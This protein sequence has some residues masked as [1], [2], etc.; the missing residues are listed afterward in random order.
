MGLFGK[1]KNIFY[2]EEIVEVP[3]E[4]VKKEE[5][6]KV[7]EFK[8]PVRRVVEEEPKKETTRP[9]PEEKPVPPVYTERELFKSE[10][11][12]KFP[13]IDEEEEE[14]V[15]R[16]RPNILDIE[17]TPKRRTEEPRMETKYNEKKEEPKEIRVF[18]PSPVISP[19]YGVLDKNYKKEEIIERQNSI[20][21][22][23][24]E[25]NYDSVR[26]KAYG[27]LED[28]F[29]NTLSRITS[30]DKIKEQIVENKTENIGDNKPSDNKSIQDLLSEIEVNRNIS[31]GD[32]EEKIKDKIENDE[33][34]PGIKFVDEV[35]S[36]REKQIEEKKPEPPKEDEEDDYEKTLEHDL[37][38]LID[39][40]YEEKEGE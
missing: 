22:N 27:T 20:R 30:K 28:E 25:M 17:R 10:T 19:V 16:T 38:N 24:G 37:F 33:E 9:I 36:F 15:R 14:P 11:T 13:V 39:S 8:T 7:E 18:K 21:H 3:K 31:I 5:S 26:R 40:M 12:F 23:P 2:D 32:L 34:V 35:D 6:R 29:E 4:E 1:I